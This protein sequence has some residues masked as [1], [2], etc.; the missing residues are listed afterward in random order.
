M[1]GDVWEPFWVSIRAAFLATA[2]VTVFACAV[3]YW[4]A[5][6]RWRGRWLVESLLSLPIALPPTV[7]GYYLVVAIGRRGPLGELW[8]DL[9]GHELQFTFTGVVT[10]Q[11]VSAMPYGLRSARAAIEDVDRRY[12]QLA[13]TMGFSRLR[14]TLLVILPLARPGLLTGVGLAFG[15]ALAD[16]GATLAVASGPASTTMPIRIVAEMFGGDP[17][18]ASRPALLQV[19]LAVAIMLAVSRLGRA[20]EI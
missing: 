10:A 3:G 5:R 7:V 18:V 11:G 6:S 2:A 16:Y 13:A 1:T 9:T 14:T 15:R 4:L 20:R 17:A 8:Q 12:E 19:V